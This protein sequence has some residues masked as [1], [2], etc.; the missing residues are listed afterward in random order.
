MQIYTTYKVKIKNYNHI[1]KQ[2]VVIYRNAVDYLIKVC[3]ANW[4][5]IEKIEGSLNRQRHVETLVHAT[6]DNLN[7]KYDFDEKFYKMQVI[8]AEGQSMKL[9]VKYPLIKAISLIGN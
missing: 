6:K 9:L 4:E 3:N 1:F 5:T 7:P 2:T 8:F